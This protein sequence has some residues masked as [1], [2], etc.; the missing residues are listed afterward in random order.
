MLT[1]DQCGLVATMT[2]SY[3]DKIATANRLGA[4]SKL[5]FM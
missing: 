1:I 4:F 5:L 2:V 3:S